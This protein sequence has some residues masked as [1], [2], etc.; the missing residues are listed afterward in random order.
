MQKQYDSQVSASKI[1]HFTNGV[2]PFLRFKTI[3]KH[4]YVIKLNLFKKVLIKFKY[5]LFKS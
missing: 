4:Y 2:S 5:N 1:T 3:L